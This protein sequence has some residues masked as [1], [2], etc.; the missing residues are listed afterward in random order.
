MDGT[1]GFALMLITWARGGQLGRRGKG[2]QVTFTKSSEQS[3]HV[4]MVCEGYH[5]VFGTCTPACIS[6]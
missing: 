1:A 3:L 6:G 5:M 4:V 2:Y